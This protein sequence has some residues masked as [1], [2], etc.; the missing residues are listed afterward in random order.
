MVGQESR[1][2]RQRDEKEVIGLGHAEGDDVDDSNSI[3]QRRLNNIDP[4]A[5]RLQLTIVRVHLKADEQ[6]GLLW[7]MNGRRGIGR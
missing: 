2:E 5:G 7:G 6:E 4:L 1:V 3:S